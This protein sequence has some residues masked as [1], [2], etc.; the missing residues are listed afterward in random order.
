[1]HVLVCHSETFCRLG[2]YRKG[3]FLFLLLFVVFSLFFPLKT[4]A[5]QSDRLCKSR[6]NEKPSDGT[7]I[8]SLISAFEDILDFVKEFSRP[9][10]YLS[11][12][13]RI[14]NPTDHNMKYLYRE[15]QDNFSDL[16]YDF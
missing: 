1:M 4:H 6:L 8:E 10:G 7:R 13:K 12:S 15:T 2:I 11:L 3:R 14:V 9:R 5:T 16:G